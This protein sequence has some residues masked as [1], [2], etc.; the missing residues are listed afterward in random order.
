MFIKT[1]MQTKEPKVL[2]FLNKRNEFMKSPVIPFHVQNLLFL[3]FRLSRDST[4]QEIIFY[5]KQSGGLKN[6]GL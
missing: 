1:V 2:V 4:R 5:C 6:A 3:L